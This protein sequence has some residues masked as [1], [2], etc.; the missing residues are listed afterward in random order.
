MQSN[1][2]ADGVLYT[3]GFLSGCFLT[4]LTIFV[5]VDTGFAAQLSKLSC[6]PNLLKD[7]GDIISGVLALIGGAF[8]VWKIN[9]QIRQ[10]DRHKKEDRER[11]DRQKEEIRERN[12]YSARAVLPN[13]LRQILDY[14]QGAVD[15][16]IHMDRS[17]E[18]FLKLML[19]SST[20]EPWK[21]P[22]PEFPDEC[23]LH[24]SRQYS[25]CG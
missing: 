24:T 7:Y 19:D 16:T 6:E 13:A 20:K 10:A 17:N 3:I 8:A 22:A 23:Y 15:L 11:D 9:D 1:R 21:R 12:D 5:A 2:I 4:A 18:E 25:L 14:T